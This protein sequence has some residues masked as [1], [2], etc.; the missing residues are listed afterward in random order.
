MDYIDYTSPIENKEI[1]TVLYKGNNQSG[2]QDDY[3]NFFDIQD[4][5]GLPSPNRGTFTYS[6]FG[7]PSRDIINNFNLQDYIPQL[8]QS[9]T[10]TTVQQPAAQQ[11]AA[12]QST[13]QQTTSQQGELQQVANGLSSITNGSG[14]NFSIS[15]LMTAI[16]KNSGKPY[17]WGV[18]GHKKTVDCSGFVSDVLDD[19]GLPVQGTSISFY[20]NMVDKFTDP[21]QAKPGDF[22]FY[23]FKANS[24]QRFRNGSFRA[25]GTP[26]HI[27]IVLEVNG[28]YV[29]V[30]E[31]SGGGVRSGI[32]WHKILD[33][34]GTPPGKIH[35]NYAHNSKGKTEFLAFGR[36]NKDK[37]AAYLQRKRK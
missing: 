17:G 7:S 8:P 36:L 21:S 4:H 34:N 20:N 16:Q 26:N 2:L 11:S 27:A 25:H 14:S 18:R 33:G 30:A 12:Q 10:Q 1:Q 9:G 22:I 5:F 15:D 31:S 35:A 19:M 13:T 29:K 28:P 24:N 6:Y 32:R 23:T 37:A 3:I